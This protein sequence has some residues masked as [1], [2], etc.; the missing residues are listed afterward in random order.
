MA[1]LSTFYKRINESQTDN[2]HVLTVKLNEQ[3]QM[4]NGHFV[5]K[6]V[7]PGAAL[8]QMVLDEVA[9]LTHNKKIVEL[10]QVKFLAVINPFQVNELELEIDFRTRNEVEMFTCVARSAETNYFKLN[11][12]FG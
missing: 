7:A 3:H 11:G 5:G 2:K 6:P 12:I 1:P 10:R 9:R 8:T 4:Y